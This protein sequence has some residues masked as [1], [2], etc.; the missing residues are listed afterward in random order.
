V[1]VEARSAEILF[2]GRF[3]AVKGGD[4]AIA[5]S[6]ACSPASR[7]CA[8]TFVGPDTGS[9]WPEDASTCA[10]SSPPSVAQRL[11]ERISILGALAPE[12]IAPCARTPRWLSSAS[13]RESQ[14]YTALEAMLQGCPSSAPDTSGLARSSSTAV[15]PEGAA[16][17]RRRPG[18]ADAARH[19]R[20]G[21]RCSARRGRAR[22]V[23]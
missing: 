14:G 4:L 21:A 3:D 8:L 1:N 9:P 7:I 10:S 13:R 2:V 11:A 16:G 6:P 23:L 12:K 17:R 18:G 5:P 22:Y 20:P 19:R 15:T